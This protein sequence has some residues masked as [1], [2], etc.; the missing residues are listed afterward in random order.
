[1]TTPKPTPTQQEND[2]F[3]LAQ[4]AGTLPHSFT[5]QQDGS[6]IDP[7]SPDPTPVTSPTWPET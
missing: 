1:M 2:K 7:Q 5:H 4:A 3:T 6:P